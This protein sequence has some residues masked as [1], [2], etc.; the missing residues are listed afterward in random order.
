MAEI[1]HVQTVMLKEELEK[2]KELTRKYTTKDALYEAVTHYFMC[3][4]KK[5]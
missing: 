5:P 1:V 3:M 4:G 2:L